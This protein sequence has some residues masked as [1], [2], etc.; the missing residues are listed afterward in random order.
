MHE[1]KLHL[2]NELIHMYK[3]VTRICREDTRLTDEP[4]G[5]TDEQSH[6]LYEKLSPLQEQIRL[7]QE[8]LETLDAVSS[9]LPRSQPAPTHVADHRFSQNK[10]RLRAISCS[11]RAGYR[12]RTLHSK[13][14]L[15]TCC[16][17]DR[18]RDWAS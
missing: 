18:M 17:F 12:L 5:R 14:G 7:K 1:K 15:H 8:E 13:S 3:E 11:T 16:V 2:C 4:G 10:R 9:E 6:A